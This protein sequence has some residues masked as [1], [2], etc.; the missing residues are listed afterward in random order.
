[1]IVAG[2]VYPDDHEGGDAGGH[3][4]QEAAD[5][6]APRDLRHGVDRVMT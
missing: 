4:G 5:G 1:M 3:Q 2:Q 6:D